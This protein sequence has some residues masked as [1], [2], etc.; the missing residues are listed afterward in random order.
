MILNVEEKQEDKMMQAREREEREKLQR[1]WL[2]RL[3]K[4]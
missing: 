1:V 4:E 2:R 3:R